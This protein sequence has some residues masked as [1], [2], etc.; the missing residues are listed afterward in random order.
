MVDLDVGIMTILNLA[1]LVTIRVILF[2]MG[3][4]WRVEYILSLELIVIS[5]R[6][7]VVCGHVVFILKC[8]RIIIPR[9]VTDEIKFVDILFHIRTLETSGCQFSKR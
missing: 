3:N 7:S 6:W 4:R 8:I 5:V 1:Q 2:L 9:E